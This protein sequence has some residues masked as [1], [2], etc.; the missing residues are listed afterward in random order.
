[1]VKLRSS[2]STTVAM[3]IDNLGEDM[4]IFLSQDITCS[5][6]DLVDTGIDTKTQW[7]LTNL[8]WL[9]IETP[10]ARLG[11]MAGASIRSS[12]NTRSSCH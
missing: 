6:Y 2:T 11:G 4:D 9:M 10:T 12:E 8:N 1:M 3:Y 7:G 5:L